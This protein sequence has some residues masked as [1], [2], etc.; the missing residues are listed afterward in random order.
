M[1]L[2]KIKEWSKLAIV[3]LF[4]CFFGVIAI[5]G[6]LYDGSPFETVFPVFAVIEGTMVKAYFDNKNI[7]S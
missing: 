1:L 5:L 7:K 6:V 2:T 3:L 4:T